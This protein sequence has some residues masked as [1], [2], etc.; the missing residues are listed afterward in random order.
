MSWEG[1]ISFIV[2]APALDGRFLAGKDLGLP[3]ISANPKK[4]QPSTPVWARTRTQLGPKFPV[5][6]QTRTQVRVCTTPDCEGEGCETDW[7]RV[8]HTSI[9]ESWKWNGFHIHEWKNTHD[10]VEGGDR[11]SR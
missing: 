11:G 7:N 2:G 9:E 1:E 5:R 3:N 8:I 4:P 6:A 10:E